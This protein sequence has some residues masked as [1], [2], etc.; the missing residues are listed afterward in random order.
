MSE[1]QCALRLKVWIE[2]LTSE[3]VILRSD[4]PKYDWKWVAEIFQFYGCWPKN[5][6]RRCGVISFEEDIQLERFNAA[7]ERFWK[8]HE[9]QRHNSLVDARGVFS[10]WSEAAGVQGFIDD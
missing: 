7:L 4:S 1:A 5:L 9:K 8:I 2:N 6:R 3:E 10:A